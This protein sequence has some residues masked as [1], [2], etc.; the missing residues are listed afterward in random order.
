MN[1]TITTVG[2]MAIVSTTGIG[3]SLTD[4]ETVFRIGSIVLTL[5]Y[6]T[7][8]FIKNYRKK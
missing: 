6:S 1:D 5:G 7:L 4:V 2:K 3:M 8:L